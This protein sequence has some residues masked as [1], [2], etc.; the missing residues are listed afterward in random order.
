MHGKCRGTFV[1]F[2]HTNRYDLQ[3]RM[4]WYVELREVLVGSRHPEAQ[5]PTRD[6]MVGSELEY[7][8][9]HRLE[10]VGSFWRDV[11]ILSIRCPCVSS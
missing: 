4:R 11:S 6:E 9:Q 2:L 3:F 10:A 8:V 1:E 7:V 5:S